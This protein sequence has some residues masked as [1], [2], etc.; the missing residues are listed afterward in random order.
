MPTSKK[1]A[2]KPTPEPCKPHEY[3]LAGMQVEPAAGYWMYCARL[4]I[5]TIE[6]VTKLTDN[7]RDEENFFPPYPDPC[8]KKGAAVIERE[9]EE[10]L[11]LARR[12]DEPCSLVG[13]PEGPIGRRE[14]I[15]KLLSLTP[16]PLGAVVVNRFP[17]EQIIRT[18]RGLARAF[19]SETP[20]L[21]H[22]HAFN[23]LVATRNWSPPR[24]ALVWATLDVAIA[25]ALQ[26]A[27]YYKWI[28][29]TPAA[30]NR[31]PLTSFRERPVEYSERL[32]KGLRV[33]FDRPDE[34][35]PA[36]NRC[37][38]GR[39]PGTLSGTPRHP[40]YPSGHSTYSGAASE[41]LA[42]FFGAQDL[43]EFLRVVPSQGARPDNDIPRNDKIRQD[44]EFMADNVGLARL[45]AGVHWRSDHVNGARLGRT[46]A[47]IV[48][49]KLASMGIDLC[50]PEPRP[51]NQCDMDKQFECR[52]DPPPT[53]KELAEQ[54]EKFRK[55]CGKGKLPD[56]DCP[57]P[58]KADDHQR[59]DANRGVQQGGQ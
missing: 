47:R 6:E 33:L 57:A 14:P 30:V 45:W 43:P 41:V 3:S 1:S 58:P 42:F 9:M 32:N 27:W 52:L 39:K 34:L 19:E 40:A 4:C 20:G 7:S 44:L 38:D 13:K 23:Y 49:A 37:P 35:N 53:R 17:G 11:E 56:D 46:V 26:A 25:A 21:F 15:S 24:Q 10:L 2:D 55:N 16:P 12:R 28:A 51:V 36:Y 59:L 31:R 8:D 48:L 18:G 22:R 5:P 50:P 54:A 29:D